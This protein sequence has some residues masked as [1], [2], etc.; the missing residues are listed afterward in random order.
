MERIEKA[1]GGAVDF[2]VAKAE[3]R[4]GKKKGDEDEELEKAVKWVAPAAPAAP[5]GDAG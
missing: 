2:L 5:G 3:G 1:I 4:W